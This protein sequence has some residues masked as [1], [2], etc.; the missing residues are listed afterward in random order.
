M[1]GKSPGL[2]KRYLPSIM[3]Q[4]WNDLEWQNAFFPVILVTVDRLHGE[5]NK[6]KC[7]NKK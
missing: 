4:I 3:I 7:F 2:W 5:T 6:N 1:M